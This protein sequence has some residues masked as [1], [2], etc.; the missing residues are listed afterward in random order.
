MIKIEKMIYIKMT[1]QQRK[2]LQAFLTRLNDISGTETVAHVELQV[3]IGKPIPEEKI[4]IKE[5][6][7][8]NESKSPTSDTKQ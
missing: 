6:E 2:N 1:E 5:E 8:K 7:K 4:I 3:A